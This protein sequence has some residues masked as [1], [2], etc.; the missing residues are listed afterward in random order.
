MTDKNIGF[1]FCASCCTYEKAVGALREICS[2]C[3]N[4]TPIFSENAYTIDSRFGTARSFV[5]RVEQ[6]CGKRVLHSIGEVEPI[7]PQALLDLLVVAPCTGN[8]LAKIATGIT[9]TCVTMAAK[10]HLRNGRPVLLAVSTND[11]LSG[12]APNLGKLLNRKD[13]FFVPFYQDNPTMKPSSV[14]AD[15]DLLPEA[16]RLALGGIQMQPLLRCLPAKV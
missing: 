2:I 14:I 12:N 5:E 13:V 1:A 9:D 10:A 3:R 8:S 15:F 11:G 7:G 6:I 4:V 16:A